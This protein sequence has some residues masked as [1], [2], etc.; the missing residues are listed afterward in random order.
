MENKS[1]PEKTD[2][3]GKVDDKTEKE[4]VKNEKAD[5]DNEGDNSDD[6]DLESVSTETILTL[7]D[8]TV[9][10]CSPAYPVCA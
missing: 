1:E 4:E 3:V 6:D 9:S 5:N 10:R 2:Q 8:N 7:L